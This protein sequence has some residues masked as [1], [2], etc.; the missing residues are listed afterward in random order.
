MSDTPRTDAEER[1]VWRERIDWWQRA[2]AGF[3][4]ARQ[5]ER[6]LSTAQSDTP[7]VEHPWKHALEETVRIMGE[8]LE[9]AERE[10]SAARREIAEEVEEIDRLHRLYRVE[11]ERADEAEK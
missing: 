3:D 8:K 6:E 9:K 1:R 2:V 11:I 4:F 5:L 10:L 7:K